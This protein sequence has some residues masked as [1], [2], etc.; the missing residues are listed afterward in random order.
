MMDEM[1]DGLKYEQPAKAPPTKCGAISVHGAD[2]VKAYFIGKCPK[3][4]DV[5]ELVCT[6][7]E[8]DL[9]EMQW[10]VKER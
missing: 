1:M 10:R 6:H 8:D 9:V 4:G 3:A 5:V 2:W 7:G